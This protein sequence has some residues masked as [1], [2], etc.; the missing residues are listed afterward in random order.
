MEPLKKGVSQ[1]RWGQGEE[2]GRRRGGGKR[3]Y[4][5]KGVGCQSESPF[6]CRRRGQR[7]SERKSKGQKK[8]TGETSIFAAEQ[9]QPQSRLA[10]RLQLESECQRHGWVSKTLAS[11]IQ[12][13]E[14]KREFPTLGIC[15]SNG[16]NKLCFGTCFLFN[17][18]AFNNINSFFAVLSIMLSYQQI[19]SGHVESHRSFKKVPSRMDVT[20]WLPT[21]SLPSTFSFPTPILRPWLW[22]GHLEHLVSL[23]AT[24]ILTIT[25]RG[26]KYSLPW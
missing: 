1:R 7:Y 5:F 11:K 15:V 21:T 12:A 20:M 24:W 6:H 2:K 14:C 10:S 8:E 26:I 4:L 17:S 13:Q 23:A 25:L 9:S 19:P 3:A 22:W 18:L 16:L